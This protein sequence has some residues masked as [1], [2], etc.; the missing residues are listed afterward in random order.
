MG[1]CLRQYSQ[2]STEEYFSETKR[3]PHRNLEGE[4]QAGGVANSEAPGLE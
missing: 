1:G 2:E 4:L 3:E